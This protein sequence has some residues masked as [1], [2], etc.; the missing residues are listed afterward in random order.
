MEMPGRRKLTEIKVDRLLKKLSL[1]F[2]PDLH[3]Y[4]KILENVIWQ[5]AFAKQNIS[6]ILA[7]GLFK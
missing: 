5:Y 4:M 7:W 6:E 1:V 2:F 3:K